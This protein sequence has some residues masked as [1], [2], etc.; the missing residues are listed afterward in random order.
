MLSR[1]RRWTLLAGCVP[2]ALLAGC[3]HQQAGPP[4][5]ATAPTVAAPP[6]P[7]A[8][9]T[10]RAAAQ[11]AEVAAKA[12]KDQQLIEQAEGTYRTGVDNYRNGHLDAARSDFDAAVDLML[13][14]GMDLKSDAPLADE[15][16]HLMNAIN[17]LEM[18]ALKQGTGFSAPIEAAPL[19][20]A[21]EV[22]FPANPVLTA[23][24]EAELKTTQSDLPLVIND[25]VAG[26]ISYFSN[27]PAGHAHLKRSLER[28]GRYKEMI[29]KDLS[30]AGLPQ[31][32]IYLAVAESGFQ[33]QV[34][35]RG[36][37]A[38]GM[39]QFMP[40]QGAYGLERNGYFDERFDPEKSS[41][42]YARYMKS[43]YAQFGDWYLAMA[44][45]N[46]GPGNVQRAVMRTG[47][48]DFWE[49]YR[50]N[51]LP[52][53]TKNYVPGIIAAAI[54]AKNPKQY[55]LDD[56]VPDAPQL[57]DTVS[58]DYAVD[59]RLVA[60][61]TDVALPEIVTINPSLL[62]MT[63]PGDAAF[64]L[65][66]PAGTREV[67][68]KR[69]QDIPDDKRASWRFHVVRA[70]ESLD[71][72]AVSFHGRASEIASANKLTADASVAPGDEL[73][74]PLAGASARSHPLHY[75]TRAGDTLVTV[76][77][78]FNVSVEDLRRWNHL[79]SAKV[80]LH[81]TLDVT[82]PVH[83]APSTRTRSPGTRSPGTRRARTAAVSTPP[84]SAA[85]SAKAGSHGAAKKTKHAAK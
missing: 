76:A 65:H 72:I 54:M 32:L 70:G 12:H 38:G 29:S 66:I 30:D 7:S 35:N 28:A 44:A 4:T 34:V 48:A 67:Y 78:R 52:T 16:D 31:D 21:D 14:S 79:K 82:E 8:E 25:Y 83:L 9:E 57:S 55:G 2:L 75:V 19:D 33:P 40:F 71:T 6:Q 36:S 27:S 58:V 20:A 26:F 62:R 85:K 42:A 3:P 39:W 49:L 69:I 51:A 5:V 60:D 74:V 13:T 11:A 84:K 43:L 61:V 47:Y 56:L 77:D 50:R 41:L 37:G 1:L 53:A 18:D 80:G 63:T 45:Y 46:W 73:V 68:L 17:A 81:R 59:L 10:V 23:K 24:V 22:T 64:D 15:F